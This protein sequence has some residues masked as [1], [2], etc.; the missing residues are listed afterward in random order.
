[1][2]CQKTIKFKF[3]TIPLY[4]F[5]TTETLVLKLNWQ[6]WSNLLIKTLNYILLLILHFIYQK[7]IILK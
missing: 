2:N 7:K 5:L 1:M 3:K 4:T 6:F